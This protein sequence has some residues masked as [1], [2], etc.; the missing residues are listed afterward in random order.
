MA[1]LIGPGSALAVPA[2][3]SLPKALGAELERLWTENALPGITFALI[4]P[5]GEEIA[6]AVGRADV[7]RD[8]PMTQHH[9]MPAGS[10]G[11]SFV[12]ATVMALVREGRLDL[13]A[14]ISRWLGERDWFADIPNAPDLTLRMLLNHSSGITADYISP[15][16]EEVFALSLDAFGGKDLEEQNVTHE[17]FARAIART[18]PTFAAGTGYGYSDS[19]YILVGL[20]IEEVAGEFYSEVRGRFLQPMS[21]RTV[22]PT[23]RRMENL[24]PGY[25]TDEDRLP[26]FPPKFA[27]SGRLILD[28]AIEWTG[29]GFAATSLDL[30]RWARLLYGGDAIGG[31]YLEDMVSSANEHARA[32]MSFRYGLGVQVTRSEEFGLRLNHGGYF[33][34]YSSF[35]EYLPEYGMAMAFQMNT[36]KG[37]NVY[38]G[39]ADRLWRVALERLAVGPDPEDPAEAGA[40]H[41]PKF[42]GAIEAVLSL[43]DEA[44]VVAYGEHHGSIPNARFRI[45]LVKHPD[46]PR[47]VDVIVIESANSFHQDTLDRYIFGEEVP[48]DKL[49]WVWRDTGS[50]VW[51]APIYEEFLAA[52]RQVNRTLP[53]EEKIRILAGDLPIDWSN[54]QSGQDMMEYADRGDFPLHIVECEVLRKDLKALLVFGSGHLYHNFGGSFITALDPRYRGRIRMLEVTPWAEQS[55]VRLRELFEL[56]SVPRLIDIAKSPAAEWNLYDALYGRSLGNE[57]T[58]GEAVDGVIYL[59]GIQEQIVETDPAVWDEPV[60]KAARARRAELMAEYADLFRAG[61]L[62]GFREW[63]DYTCA[64]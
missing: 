38:R 45:E 59:G 11:K 18:E 10:I 6:L 54:V 21:L 14:R 40:E 63:S 13:D 15:G 8:I 50:Q 3:E 42:T 61:S 56:G 58:L 62:Q 28:P 57:P 17:D 51:D 36:K 32:D 1:F 20:I 49:V 30:A 26:F 31:K 53:K 9:V 23:S 4:L 64:E 47:R 2:E 12:A 44:D 37:Y 35:M 41:E 16:M 27:D 25:E 55:M 22:V 29:G 19:N 48:R 7:E 33:F 39:Y 34:G 24:A 46:F 43:Y 60:Y 52:V 5:D